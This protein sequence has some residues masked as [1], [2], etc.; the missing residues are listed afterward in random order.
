M[1][2]LNAFELKIL[3]LPPQFRPCPGR[4]SAFGTAVGGGAQ[5]V[6]TAYTATV[7]NTPARTDARAD[8]KYGQE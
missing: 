6:A 5:V 4:P 3:C 2:D 1:G 8:P 7:A